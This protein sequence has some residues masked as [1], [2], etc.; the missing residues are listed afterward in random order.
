MEFCRPVKCRYLLV[1]CKA[2]VDH[3]YCD[4][5]TL[6][7][8]CQALNKTIHNA[9]LETTKLVYYTSKDPRD[10]TNAIFLLGAFLCLHVGATIEEAWQPFKALRNDLVQPYRDAT[11]VK[12]TY[13]L[14]VKD[15]WAGLMRAVKTGLYK[16]ESFD[17]NE[18]CNSLL[19]YPC[20]SIT[21]NLLQVYSPVDRTWADLC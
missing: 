21:N 14:H 2:A 13:D 8:I 12:S 10:V 1:Q 15:C 6:H 4:A 3:D 20:Q 19:I 7:H 16:P 5:G 17:K 18:V 11:W 9:E